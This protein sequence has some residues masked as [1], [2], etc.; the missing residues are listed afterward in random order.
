MPEP[1]PLIEFAELYFDNPVG[2]VREV[3]GVEPDEWQAAAMNA[4]AQRQRRVAIRS[5][6][7]VGKSTFAAWTS[8]WFILTR[9]PQKTVVTSQSAPQLWDALW[10]EIKAWAKK[11]PAPLLPLLDVKS[12]SIEL[13]G[14]PDESFISARTSRPE[15]PEAMAGVHSENVLLIGDE[16]SGIPEQVFEAASGSMSG[17]HATTILL[18]NPVRSSGYFY[19]CFHANKADWWTLKV[20]CTDSPRCNSDFIESMKRKYGEDS[21]AYRVRVLGEFPQKDDNTVIPIELIETAIDREVSVNP[22]APILWGLDVARFGNDCSCL[23]KRKANVVIEPPRTW[24]GLDLMQTVGVV[25]SEYDSASEGLKPLEILV[26]SIGV[27]AGVVDRL[28]ELGLPAR[29]INVS[30]SPALGNT[31]MNLRA[32]L[33]YSAKDWFAKRDCS[34]PKDER[35]R[36]ELAMVRYGFQSG[37]SKLKIESKDEIRKR[38]HDSPDVADAFVL[39]FASTAGTALYG[40]SYSSQWSKPIRRRLALV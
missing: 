22:E 34:I 10:A 30:E 19:D 21:N 29:G 26:D 23:V 6:H 15:A 5:G 39:T 13:M 38:G 32:E 40:R 28:I 35:L 7:G 31:Y 4:V 3:F 20:S 18:G 14:A 24:K 8:L 37:S 12:E 9:F 36:G 33:W 16:A 25:K 1:N 11:L 2:F 17:H 27:G